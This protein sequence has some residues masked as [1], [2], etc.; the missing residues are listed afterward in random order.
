MLR[1]SG[2]GIPKLMFKLLKYMPFDVQ[3][4]FIL[5]FKK[6]FLKIYSSCPTVFCGMYECMYTY[7]CKWLPC[8]D[9]R[10]LL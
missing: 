7:A 10:G 2:T 4:T 3:S 8:D 5:H 9:S 6:D 1:S